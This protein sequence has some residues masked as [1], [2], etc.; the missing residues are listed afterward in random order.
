MEFF[1]TDFF[2]T[3]LNRDDKMMYGVHCFDTSSTVKCSSMLFDRDENWFSF[4]LY[5]ITT[6]VCF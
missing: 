1:Q 2:L 5:L 4:E 6:S 3:K